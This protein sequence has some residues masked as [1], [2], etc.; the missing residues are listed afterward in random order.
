VTCFSDRHGSFVLPYSQLTF[1]RRH[2]EEL[3]TETEQ[4]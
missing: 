2:D 1:H 3:N 4:Y